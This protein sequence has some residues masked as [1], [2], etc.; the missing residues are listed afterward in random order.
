MKIF[1]ILIL[2]TLLFLSDCIS[3]FAQDVQNNVSD[4]AF[5]NLKDYNRDFN[6]D[7]RYATENNFLN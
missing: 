5:V 3:V 6:Y 4:S 1:H 7:M 2:T